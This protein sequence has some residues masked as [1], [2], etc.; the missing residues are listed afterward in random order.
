MGFV[1]TLPR[2]ERFLIYSSLRQSGEFAGAFKHIGSDDQETLRIELISDA[3]EYLKRFIEW[4]N[5]TA[6]GGKTPLQPLTRA[7][8]THLYFVCIHPFQDG[9]GELDALWRKKHWRKTSVS[10][11]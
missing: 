11:A 10:Q 8:L 9:T 7:A 4:F 5:D 1:T 3:A 2:D 6:P